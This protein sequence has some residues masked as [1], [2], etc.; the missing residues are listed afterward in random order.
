[1]TSVRRVP[2]PTPRKRRDRGSVVAATLLVIV[3]S[4][5]SAVEVERAIEVV[6]KSGLEQDRLNAIG[7]ADR[8][9]ADA[10]ATADLGT[11]TSFSGSGSINGGIGTYSYNATKGGASWAVSVTGTSGESTRHVRFTM[12]SSGGALSSSDWSE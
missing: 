5:L 6:H 10:M 8:G 3:L 4:M 12:T 7:A 11:A 2:T 1:M 9:V